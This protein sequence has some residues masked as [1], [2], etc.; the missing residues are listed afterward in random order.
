MSFDAVVQGM[1][2]RSD[3]TACV[4]CPIETFGQDGVCTGLCRL[5]FQTL[6]HLCHTQIA[7]LELCNRTW[8]KDH[9]THVLL[10]RLRMLLEL[11]V[12]IVARYMCMEQLFIFDH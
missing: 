2:S 8:A 9:V 3:R 12:L 4:A 10:G 7:L 6:L 11:R 5:T 1:T